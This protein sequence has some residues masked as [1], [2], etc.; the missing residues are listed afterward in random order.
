MSV[1]EASGLQ[2]FHP[3]LIDEDEAFASGAG[4]PFRNGAEVLGED[5]HEADR[6]DTLRYTD[7]E[8]MYLDHIVLRVHGIVHPADRR[9]LI[10]VR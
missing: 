8:V 1:S 7:T 2:L 4:M 9:E 10:A 3:D 6:A 5:L